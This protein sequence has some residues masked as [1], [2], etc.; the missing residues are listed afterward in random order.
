MAMVHHRA[1]DK[2]IGV[3]FD[4]VTLL[5]AL[6]HG[7]AEC[8]K[9]SLEKAQEPLEPL[10]TLFKGKVDVVSCS[11]R[12][13]SIR[14]YERF[15]ALKCPRLI[16]DCGL[17]KGFAAGAKFNCAKYDISGLL[18]LGIALRS[19]GAMALLRICCKMWLEVKLKVFAGHGL[20]LRQHLLNVTRNTSFRFSIRR[21]QQGSS[22]AN[23]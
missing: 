19:S 16:M 23:Y 4:V 7:T 15:E 18:N 9:R 3:E 17:H 21:H 1:T 13:A 5:Y 20:C 8:T 10:L 11:D 12:A 2:Y 22:W 14:R 6:D